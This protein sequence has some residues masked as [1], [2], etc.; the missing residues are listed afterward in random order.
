MT[1][2]N[3]N[4]SAIPNIT[5][6]LDEVVPLPRLLNPEYLTLAKEAAL[7]TIEDLDPDGTYIAEDFCAPVWEATD[8]EYEHKQL[9]LAISHLE[10][11]KKLPIKR[12]SDRSDHTAQ[13]RIISSRHVSKESISLVKNRE[14][15]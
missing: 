6:Q 8:P 5:P 4:C 7:L 10:E 11:D 1:T 12:I 3:D 14:K 2:Q 15:K 13:Y 9:G